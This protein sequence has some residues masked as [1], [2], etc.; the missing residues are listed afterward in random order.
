[1]DSH[2]DRQTEKEDKKEKG[3]KKGVS[4]E[5]VDELN[6]E[7]AEAELRIKRILR[8]LGCDGPCSFLYLSLF[9]SS[10]NSTPIP[11]VY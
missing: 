5:G 6:R 9:I 2:T 4:E 7:E 1:M 3:E 11:I 10:L 8:I